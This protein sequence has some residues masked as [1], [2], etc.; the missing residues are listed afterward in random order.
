L[1]TKGG[2]LRDDGRPIKT[3]EWER[4]E[5]ESDEEGVEAPLGNTNFKVREGGGRCKTRGRNRER[6]GGLKS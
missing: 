3:D 6:T 4:G 2:S 1:L 5:N